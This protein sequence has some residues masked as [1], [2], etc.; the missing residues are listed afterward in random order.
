MSYGVGPCCHDQQPRPAVQQQPHCGV[1]LPEDRT[2][3]LQVCR[4]YS[5][6]V[7]GVLHE[8][9]RVIRS[10][11]AGASRSADYGAGKGRKA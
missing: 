3:L 11:Q 7:M 1:R 6:D 8:P 2:R 5:V 9:K 4:R 10:L